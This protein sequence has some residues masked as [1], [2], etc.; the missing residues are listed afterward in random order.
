MFHLSKEYRTGC[1]ID[2]QVYEEKF[3]FLPN[4]TIIKRTA[5]ILQN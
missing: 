2:G 4:S 1:F 5:L 3:I